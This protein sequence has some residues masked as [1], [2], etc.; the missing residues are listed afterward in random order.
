[1]KYLRLLLLPFGWLYGLVVEAIKFSY[2]QGWRHSKRTEVATIVV[3]NLSMGGTGKTPHVEYVVNHLGHYHKVAVLSRGYGRKSRGFRKVNP[4]DLAEDVGDEPLQM[5]KK[6]PDIP[7]FVCEKRLLGIEK[8]LK[9]HPNI[10][11][12]VLDDAMQHWAVRADS[13]FMLTTWQQP[14]F[15]DFPLPAGK[16]REFRNGYKRADII[17]VSKCP[18]NISEAE[19]VDFLKKLKP[20]PYQKVFFSY[21]SYA[22]P[23]LYEKSDQKIGLE[24]LDS[25]KIL[26]ITGIANPEI[27]EQ[28]L[29][30]RGASLLKMRYL[31]HHRFTEA[32]FKQIFKKWREISDKSEN[33]I[34]MTTEKDA[35]RLGGL[36]NGSI[37]LYILPVKVEIA[38]GK[39]PELQRALIEVMYK[40]K[41]YPTS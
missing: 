32:D 3:G 40:K 19:R 12:L 30:R 38:F 1:M 2:R 25:R 29:I 15:E 7:F 4:I 22:D 23:Y 13:Y 27:M 28:E 9:S 11:M 26:I 41:G 36:F 34:I 10:Q 35:T 31:D 20:F 16:L 24:Q 21:F 14:F 6:Y 8:I 17:I 18:P 39:A 5:A 37:P 33:C